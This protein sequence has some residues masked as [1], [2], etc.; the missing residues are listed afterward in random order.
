MDISGELTLEPI[1][2]AEEPLAPFNQI[3]HTF[4][5]GVQKKRRRQI[6]HTIIMPQI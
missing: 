3:S 1:G 2:E 4:A 6:K 5:L